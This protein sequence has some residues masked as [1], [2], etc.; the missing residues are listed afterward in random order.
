MIT[1]LFIRRPVLAIVISL[2]I[3]VLGTRAIGMLSVQQYPTIESAVITVNTAYTGASPETIT[4]FITTPLEQAIAQANGIDYITSSSTQNTSMIQA[5]LVLNYDHDKALTE[6][7]TQVNSVLNQLP[8]EAQLPV[9][10]VA[11]GETVDS[12]YI[13]F[14]SDTLPANRITDY[15]VRVIQPKLQAVN[16]VQTAEVLGSSEIALRIWIDPDKLAGYGLT[17]SQIAQVLSDNNFISAAGRTDG[18]TFILNLNSNT[19]LTTVDEFKDM[20]IKADNGAII[21]LRDVASV[22]LGQENYNSAV[23]KDGKTAVF[24]GIVVAPGANLLTVLGE[25]KKTFAA[26]QQQIPAGIESNIV[27]DSSLFVDASIDEVNSALFEAFL[28]VTVV[29]FIFLGSMRALFIPVIAIPLSIVG[30]FFLMLVLGYTINILTLLALVL[31]IGLVVDDAIIV[32]E[33]VSRHMELGKSAFQAAILSARELA[34]PIVAISIVLIAVY[35]PIGFMGGLTGALFTEFAFT[36]AGAVGISAVI[37]L[38]LSP[39]LC[40]RMLKHTHK[41]KFIAW[42]DTKFDGFKDNYET[43]LSN[44]L[45]YLPVV[46]VFAIIILASNFFLFES[47]QSELAPQEDQGI[48]MTQLTADTNSSLDQTEI[49]SQAVSKIFKSYPETQTTFEVNGLNGAN[50][51]PNLN[52]NMGGMV[53]KPW[54]ERKR[55]SNQLQPMV[56]RQLEGIAGAQIAAFQLPS[57]PGGGSGLPVQFVI[58]SA[59]PL[60]DMKPIADQIT[61]KGRQSGKF[62]ALFPDLYYNMEQGQIKIDREKVAEFGL[63]LQD[64]GNAISAALSENYIN[65]FDYMGRSYQVIPQTIRQSRLNANPLLDYYINTAS[66]TPISLATVATITKNIAPQSVNHFQQMNSITLQ[67]IPA[68]GVSM[69][70]AISTLNDIAKP[71]LPQGYTIDYASQSR[72]FMEQSDSMAITFLLALIIIF[73]SLAVLFNSFRDPLIVLISVPMSIC[74]AM[75][76]ISLGVGGA[77]LNI[78]TE[79]GLITLIGLISKHGILIVEFANDLQEQGKNKRDAVIEAAAIRF[80]PILMTT[81]AMVLGVIPLIMA[82]G[83]GAESR[84]NIGLVIATGISIG[85]CFTLFVVPAMY[86]LIAEDYAKRK[87]EEEVVLEG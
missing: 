48:I 31:A 5:N 8:T 85:T 59:Q 72:Q 61:Q 77:T 80:R 70:E 63:T 20:V 37:A 55:T 29:I 60:G 13:G 69:G 22:S 23:T 6:I 82:S 27:Y 12:M 75:I 1:D 35:M 64:V 73:L 87:P 7:N 56:Q 79:V 24:I 44:A 18:Q 84:F 74:G 10:T 34:K 42:F 36:L 21:R 30:T 45:N 46:I 81:A 62:Q 83:A 78:Y 26:A 33:N 65:Y 41:T 39:M 57:L 49:Y 51:A 15:L 43:K 28:I 9:L 58:Q 66:G 40:S 52:L 25:V 32:V 19:N 86:L 53:L 4:A 71:L 14:N 50:N 16:G 54:G 3:L 68:P 17:T 67:G 38:T 47:S 11:I 76:F 2:M